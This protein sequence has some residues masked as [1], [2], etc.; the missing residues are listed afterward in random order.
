MNNRSAEF[1][2]DSDDGGSF[3][4]VH[5]G[6]TE[7]IKFVT[8][9]FSEYLLEDGVRE[10][11]GNEIEGIVT[12]EQSTELT[13]R[14]AEIVF[15]AKRAN[16]RV[17]SLDRVLRILIEYQTYCEIHPFESTP[18][19]RFCRQSSETQFQL[20][21]PRLYEISESH[22]MNEEQAR[23]LAMQVDLFN[24]MEIY[25]RD[26][27]VGNML[28]D[29]NENYILIDFGARLNSKYTNFFNI[30]SLQTIDPVFLQRYNALIKPLVESNNDNKIEEARFRLSQSNKIYQERD[31]YAFVLTFLQLHTG[32]PLWSSTS[33]IAPR[34]GFAYYE[35]LK[36]MI[37]M[38]NVLNK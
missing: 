6:E 36:K 15:N 2:N 16:L 22:Q 3:G 10:I 18:V 34:S 27:R 7:A 17:N 20:V 37:F 21:L 28:V 26:I 14:I 29:T 32:T 12:L 30:G 19:L 38:Q 5:L 9:D 23:L 13:K 35:S 8:H 31:V 24:R 33:L 25:H 4:E 11:I 1:L